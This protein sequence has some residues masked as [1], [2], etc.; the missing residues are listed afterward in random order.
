VAYVKVEGGVT[1]K[2]AVVHVPGQPPRYESFPDPVPGEHEAV[3]QV[4][5]AGLHPVVKTLA[6]GSHY[7]S[8]D[9]LPLVPGVDGVGR[10]DDGRRIYFAGPRAPHHRL[11]VGPATRAAIPRS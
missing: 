3:V 10:L 7:G 5:A 4:T 11:P 9:R 1:M 8:T 2:A 6:G